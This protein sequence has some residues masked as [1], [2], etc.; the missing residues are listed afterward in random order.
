MVTV[1]RRSRGVR[2]RLR[3][4]NL[5]NVILVLRFVFGWRRRKE[6]RGRKVWSENGGH[7][8][9]RE[10]E[11]E[12]KKEQKPIFLSFSV[13]KRLMLSSIHKATSKGQRTWTSRNHFSCSRQLGCFFLQFTNT[14]HSKQLWLNSKIS[15]ILLK[16]TKFPSCVTINVSSLL[17]D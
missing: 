6:E 10:R 3:K 9:E 12:R 4:R 14:N 7:V 17:S 5:F 15:W 8:T 1:R 13:G 2:G 11:R 16:S